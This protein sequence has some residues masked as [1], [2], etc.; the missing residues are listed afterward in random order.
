ML[1]V[2]L[3]PA[4]AEAQGPPVRQGLLSHETGRIF[5]EVVGEG[6]P[7]VVVHG[8]PGLDHNYLRPGLD[9]L[10]ASTALI[11]YDQ[12]GTGRSGA[13]LDGENINLEA[14]LEDIEAL[15]LALGHDRITVLGHSYGGLIAMAYAMAHPDRTRALILMASVEPGIRWQEEAAARAAEARAP[16]DAEELSRLAASPGYEARDPN[17]VSEMYRL[18]FRG[19]LRDPARVDDLNLQ[20]SRQ[21]AANGADVARLLGASIGPVDWWEDLA[22]LPVPTLVV[23]GRHDATPLGMSQE[24]VEVL[25]NGELAVLETGHFPYVEDPGGLVAAVAGFLARLPR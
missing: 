9:V 24:L 6:A 5:Y 23:H 8:G 12:R 19:T 1:V 13:P 21:T 15:R 20:V 11:Y 2:P 4:N 14:F 3:L 17:T 22:E 7:I 16:E 10:A 25:P 18:A